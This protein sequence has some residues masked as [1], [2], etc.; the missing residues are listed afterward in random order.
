MQ[1]LSLAEVRADEALRSA[2]LAD[3]VTQ[4]KPRIQATLRSILGSRARDLFDEGEQ[5]FLATANRALDT[6][7]ETDDGRGKHSPERW[8]IWR[9]LL[10]VRDVARCHIGRDNAPLKREFENKI[11]YA[12]DL[13]PHS[14]Q[15]HRIEHASV[16]VDPVDYADSAIANIT[17]QEFLQSLTQPER[18][19]A[20][21][22][23]YGENE[24]THLSCQCPYGSR[25]HSVVRDIAAAINYSEAYVYGVMARVRAKAAT[26]FGVTVA[27]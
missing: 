27:R 2:F 8:C 3:L 13:E 11:V 14:A 6:A 18:D 20:L 5:A 25:K 9:G 19:V 16:Y 17:V 12:A 23:L 7:R 15:A 10:A 4:A 26:A 21:L 22:M 24:Y 1:S